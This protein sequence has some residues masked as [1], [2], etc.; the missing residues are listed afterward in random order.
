VL[1]FGHRALIALIALMVVG[2]DMSHQKFFLTGL[3]LELRADEQKQNVTNQ[4]S[5]YG[6]T[7]QHV[8]RHMYMLRDVVPSPCR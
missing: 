3:V 4:S 7:L 8:L 6:G 1:T 5:G 2:V